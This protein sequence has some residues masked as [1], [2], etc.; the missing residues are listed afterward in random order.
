[1][2]NLICIFYAVFDTASFVLIYGKSN[3]VKYLQIPGQMNEGQSTEKHLIFAVCYFTSDFLLLVKAQFLP[4][5]Q[6][7]FLQGQKISLIKT[8]LKDPTFFIIGF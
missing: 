7:Y 3:K 8:H 6:D 2:K 1:M 4:K 5:C